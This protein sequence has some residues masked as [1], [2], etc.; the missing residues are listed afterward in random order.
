MHLTSVIIVS[1][2]AAS[3]A[4]QPTIELLVPKDQC[5][6]VYDVHKMGCSFERFYTCEYQ[7]ETI[8]RADTYGESGIQYI[9]FADMDGNPISTWTP[10]GENNILGVIDSPKRFALETLVEHGEDR[11][12]LVLSALHPWFADPVTEHFR[13]TV[14]LTGK[15]LD[16]DGVAFH[17]AKLRGYSQIN[18][19]QDSFDRHYYFDLKT[20]A[21]VRG[22]DVPSGASDFDR[23]SY[24]PIKVVYPEH[25]DFQIDRPI[26]QC[27]V[28]SLGPLETGP[29]KEG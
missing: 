14:T 18:S 13:G 6:P 12:D 8:Q 21:G 16:V 15:I 2:L 1:A 4:A 26:Y 5:V 17:E 28:I 29:S 25:P 27:G 7:G 3:A 9:E 23:S 20:G 10:D 24:E 19:F 22:S 11:F